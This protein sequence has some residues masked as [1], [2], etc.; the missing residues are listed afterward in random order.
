MPGNNQELIKVQKN[1]S[2]IL[3]LFADNY[4]KMAS[5]IDEHKIKCKTE[6][7]IIQVFQYYNSLNGK[8]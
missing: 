4:N 3:G 7:D 2:G 1:K 5:F 8:K 6:K